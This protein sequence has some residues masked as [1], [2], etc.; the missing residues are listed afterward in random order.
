MK[1]VYLVISI[2]ISL[3]GMTLYRVEDHTINHSAS[4]Y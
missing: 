1:T 2:T 3:N 4:Q